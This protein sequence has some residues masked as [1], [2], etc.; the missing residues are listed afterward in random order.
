MTNQ[1]LKIAI[2]FVK[3]AIMML[4]PATFILAILSFS[5]YWDYFTLTTLSTMYLLIWAVI[6][7][8]IKLYYK[9]ENSKWIIL[10]LQFFAILSAVY[11][12]YD[13]F[14]SAV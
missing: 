11:F 9:N 10:G 2:V 8:A 4:V 14:M 5:R 12:S 1:P 6:V 7:S 13:A 3:T